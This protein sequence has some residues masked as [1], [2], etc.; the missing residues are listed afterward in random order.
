VRRT[1]L[2]AA[3]LTVTAVVATTVTAASASTN[4]SL[5]VRTLARNGAPIAETAVVTSLNGT[6]NYSVKTF[7]AKAMPNGRYTV[8]TDIWNAT[9]HTDTMAA[10]VVTVSGATTTTIDA[11]AGKLVTVS[12][13]SSPGPDFSQLLKGEVC[14][15]YGLGNVGVWNN[16]GYLYLIPYNSSYVQLA[17]MST[18]QNYAAPSNEM[19]AVTGNTTGLNATSFGFTQSSLA[20][21]S[22]QVRKGPP[23]ASSTEVGIQPDDSTTAGGFPCQSYLAY[24]FINGPLPEI[25]ELHLSAGTWG[26]ETNGMATVNGQ[27]PVIGSTT[28]IQ[29]LLA[30]HSYADVVNRAAWGPAHDLPYVANHTLYFDTSHMF[31]DPTASG[32]EC[33]ERSSSVLTL[34]SSTVS[35]Q[36]N[37]TWEGT[38]PVFIKALPKAG[39]YTFSV[40]ATRYY[41]GLAVP[42]TTLSPKVAVRYSLNLNPATAAVAPAYTVQFVPQVLDTSN[43]AP[44]GSTSKVS[45]WIGRPAG[46]YGVTFPSDPV[47]TVGAWASFDGGRTWHA[48]PV[49][50][51]AT[52]T[53]ASIVNPTSGY[54]SLRANVTDAAGNA[55]LVTVYN[56]YQIGG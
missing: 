19:Y 13:D 29:T 4:G 14:A 11:R 20:N 27:N 36:T 21:V 52:S 41:P 46:G 55:T 7:T 42:A 8:I 51:T 6:L 56:A 39:R 44:A 50:R 24:G 40:T 16:P 2:V 3:A 48:I 9:D 26:L 37:T 33:C 1:I 23:I 22:M 47:K 15:A 53:M 45:L 17:Y 30:G 31:T 5:T 38:N 25:A 35:S 54:V 43:R 49:A 10:E 28:T 12:L 18:W 32:S 34:G